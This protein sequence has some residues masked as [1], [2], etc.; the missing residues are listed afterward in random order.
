MNT[1]KQI[2]AGGSITVA[3]LTLLVMIMQSNTALAQYQKDQKTQEKTLKDMDAGVA[4]ALPGVYAYVEEM[5]DAGYDVGKYLSQYIHY[6]EAAEK[7]HIEGR[8]V[9]KF[10]VTDKG[11]ISDISVLNT[12]DKLL[13]DEAVRV[14]KTMPAWKPGKQNG[15]PVNVYFTLPIVFKLP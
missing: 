5:P 3:V 1:Q 10:I 11:V 6:P 13:S 12:P 8:V 9:L 4:S 2:R 7:N 14:V 15:K